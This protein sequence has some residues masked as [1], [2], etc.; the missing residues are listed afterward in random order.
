[1]A[2]HL[3]V[4]ANT[5]FDHLPARATGDGWDVETVAILDVESPGEESPG[6]E[7]DGDELAVRVGLEL[8]ADVDGL[9]HHAAFLSLSPT[10][11]RTFAGDLERV[12]TAAE[13]GETITSG[14]H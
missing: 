11:A 5:T 2:R 4:T 7:T 8:D 12:A 14:R 3:N 6:D 10:Q 13:N 1:M 9:P